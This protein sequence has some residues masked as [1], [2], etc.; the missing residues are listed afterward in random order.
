[1][2]GTVV[3]PILGGA[4]TQK[5]SRRWC[6]CSSNDLRISKPGNFLKHNLGFYINLP[7]G[8]VALAVISLVHISD[9]RY[10]SNTN[11]TLYEAIDRLDLIVFCLFA[12]T[13]IM[14]PLSLQWGGSTYAWHSSTIIG[15]FVGS[16]IAFIVFCVWGSERGDSA[17][18]PPSILSQ[19]V[20][21]SV[22]LSISHSFPPSRYL[23]TTCLSGFKQF[24]AC[25]QS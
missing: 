19:K 25:R 24:W 6:K 20:V 8:G 10:K 21:Y 11:D 15:L 14:L 4:L 18:V 3:G 17:M 1:M 13:C 9:S 12:P 16:G 23:N 22:I 2:L 7:A 5:A